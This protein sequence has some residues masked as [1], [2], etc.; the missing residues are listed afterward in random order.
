MVST[1][2]L[3]WHSFQVQNYVLIFE[4]LKKM[5]KFLEVNSFLKI[6]QEEAEISI[7][8]CLFGWVWIR[9]TLL[10]SKL[11]SA[12]SYEHKLKNL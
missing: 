9:K 3:G 6:T 1:F 5:G 2:S 4:I 11:Q 10:E 7:S 8:L 12:V